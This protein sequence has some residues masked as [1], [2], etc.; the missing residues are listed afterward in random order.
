MPRSTTCATRPAI[1]QDCPYTEISQLNI[2]FIVNLYITT[3]FAS[4]GVGFEP[5]GELPPQQFS[6]LSHSTALPSFHRRTGGII[7]ISARDAST[8]ILAVFCHLCQPDPGSIIFSLPNARMI[9]IVASDTLFGRN[10]FVF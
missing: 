2:L 9:C 10:F 6:R 1:L 4:E 7:L 3:I 8:E 5:T